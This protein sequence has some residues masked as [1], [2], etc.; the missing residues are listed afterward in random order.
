MFET[1]F[2][3]T[4]IVMVNSG[5]DYAALVTDRIYRSTKFMCALACGKPIVSTA[6]L[7]ALQQTKSRVDPMR[8]LLKDDEGE[9][10]YNF[11]LA[12]TVGESAKKGLFRH[13]SI[14]VTPNTTPGPDVLK[15]K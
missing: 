11:C 2:F 12:K 1:I 9:K 10:K 13:Y 15:G 8:F 14:L 6:W 5:D 4:D 7:K 3:F